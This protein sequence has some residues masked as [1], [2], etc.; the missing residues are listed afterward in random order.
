M[1]G[2]NRSLSCLANCSSEL[3]AHFNGDRLSE[4]LAAKANQQARDSDMVNS[5][6]LHRREDPDD[7]FSLGA[8]ALQ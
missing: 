6:H 7:P 8:D 3:G 2:G 1:S 4:A 5:Y